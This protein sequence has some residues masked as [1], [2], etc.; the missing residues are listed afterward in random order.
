MHG[1]PGAIETMG[2]DSQQ[3]LGDDPF[4]PILATDVLSVLG[5]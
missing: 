4:R 1:G 5:E 2:V 3:E